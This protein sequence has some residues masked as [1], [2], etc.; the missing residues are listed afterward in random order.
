MI[1]SIF[2]ALS[3]PVR[4]RIIETIGKGEMCACEIPKK[5]GNAQPT[6]S[7]YLKILED[8]GILSSR[9]EGKKIL[10]SVKNGAVFDLIESAKL[11]G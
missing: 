3:N 11:I 8:A 10:Y 5:V 9:R 4:L 7:Q 2:D 1:E 6:V